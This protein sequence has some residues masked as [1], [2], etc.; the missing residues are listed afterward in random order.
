MLDAFI[1]DHILKKEREKR[2]GWEPQPLELPLDM[3]IPN[4][5]DRKDTDSDPPENIGIRNPED[6]DGITVIDMC[7]YSRQYYQ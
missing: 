2:R 4:S 5:Y 7:S 3:P 1:I 6:D